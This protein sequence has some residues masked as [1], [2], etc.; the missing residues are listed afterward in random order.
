MPAS[1]IHLVCIVSRPMTN[2]RYIFDEQISIRQAFQKFLQWLCIA[3]LNLGGW[4]MHNSPEDVGIRAEQPLTL[5]EIV[6][7]GVGG[8]ARGHSFK[9]FSRQCTCYYHYKNH[10]IMHVNWKAGEIWHVMHRKM[11]FP[12]H[13]DQSPVSAPKLVFHIRKWGDKLDLSVG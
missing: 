9:D 2:I 4:H 8:S 1:A 7:P 3:G 6:P 11:L 13:K 12:S 10:S 5:A